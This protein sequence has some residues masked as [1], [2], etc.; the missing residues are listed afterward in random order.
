MF[1]YYIMPF[2]NK[3]RKYL[4][5][6]PRRPYR[7]GKKPT[8]AF[9]KAVNAVVRKDIETK[10]AFRQY[11]PVAYNSG[12]DA[13]SEIQFIVPN[14]AQGSAENERIGDRIQGRTLTIKGI[15]TQYLGNLMSNARI[16][17]RIFIVQ[18]KL[19]TN[20]PSILANASN[21]LPYLLRKG[22]TT[23]PFTGAIQDLH[24]PVN[25]DLITC[26][27]DKVIYTSVPYLVTSVGAQDGYHSTKFFQKT[28][29]LRNKSLKY[30]TSYESNLQP[31]NW[32]PVILIGYVHL[33]GSSPDVTTAQM[34]MSYDSIFTY[35]DA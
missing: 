7:R 29:K 12:I 25:T 31:V 21:W 3:R 5:G 9:A 17:T 27:Y 33:D 35:E 4:R 30:Q 24:A 22:G 15:L 23:T 20:Q 16:A 11:L 6:R 8:K 10:Q 1:S 18:P 13:S 28:F 2:V 19:F 34:T 14:I 32:S 26:Y